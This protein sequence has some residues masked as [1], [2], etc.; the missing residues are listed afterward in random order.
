MKTLFIFLIFLISI[1]SLAQWKNIG[2]GGAGNPGFLYVD[3]TVLF[4]YDQGGGLYQCPLSTLKF[5]ECDSGIFE[6]QTDK[7]VTSICRMGKNMFEGGAGI[8]RSTNNGK[9]WSFLNSTMFFSKI[10]AIV[11][12][13]TVLIADDGQF[14]RSTDYGNTWTTGNSIAIYAFD[15]VGSTLFGTGGNDTWRS[16]DRGKSWTLISS[17]IGGSFMYSFDSDIFVWNDVSTGIGLTTN[18]GSS[19]SAIGTPGGFYAAAIGGRNI[20]AGAKYAV[21]HVSTDMGST[22][23]A[24]DNTGIIS[25]ML[26]SAMCVFDTFLLIGGYDQI[27]GNADGIFCRP[28]SQLLPQ[29][30]VRNGN[31][32]QSES[33]S[34]YPNPM[35]SNCTIAFSL[36]N[37]GPVNITVLD[38]MGRVLAMPFSGNL[39]PG[40]HAVPLEA[41]NLPSGTYWCQLTAEGKQRMAK[42]TILK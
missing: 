36:L 17:S 35:G 29:S 31:P 1:P 4:E 32:P 11:A 9:S 38:A 22:W 5:T 8:A 19:W 21:L 12:V 24:I 10:T 2:G 34:V 28:I 15:S 39:E 6:G 14:H 37:E 27:T 18:E 23:S 40:E 30:G 42:V 41:G 16:N 26:P 20:F 25:D 13:D 3:D 7:Q 33:L